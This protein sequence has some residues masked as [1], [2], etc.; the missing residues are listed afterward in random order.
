MPIYLA[1]AAIAGRA[2]ATSQQAQQNIV[3]G[4]AALGWVIAGAAAWWFGEDDPP[5]SVDYTYEF[6]PA[7]SWQCCEHPYAGCYGP[8]FGCESYN[9]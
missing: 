2:I 5:G 1:G 8:E 9:E 6:D 4:L 7:P 3:A